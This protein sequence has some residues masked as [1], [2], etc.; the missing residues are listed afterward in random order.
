MRSENVLRLAP[1]SYVNE[2]LVAQVESL[3]ALIENVLRLVLEV[4]RW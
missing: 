1:E 3:V 4:V 2:R